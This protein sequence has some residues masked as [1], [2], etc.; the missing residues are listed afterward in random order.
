M[1]FSVDP[2]THSEGMFHTVDPYPQS[3]DA[4]M[5]G[6]VDPVDH[7]RHQVQP[8]QVRGEQVGQRMLGHRHEL[9]RHRR[10]AGRRRVLL[11]ALADR[12]QRDR[13]MAG[14]TPASIRSTAI[15]PSSSVEE[16]NS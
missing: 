16:N 7:E 5:V 6:E 12:F 11:H 13:V 4:Q 14:D 1:V 10:L 9:P 3:D 8:G 2:S 15:R